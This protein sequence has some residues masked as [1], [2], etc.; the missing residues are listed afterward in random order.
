MLSNLR[1][2]MRF[3]NSWKSRARLRLFS[4]RRLRHRQASFPPRPQRKSRLRRSRPSHESR[5]RVSTVRMTLARPLCLSRSKQQA[6]RSCFTRLLGPPRTQPR[7]CSLLLPRSALSRQ[8]LR[9]S[10]RAPF[11]TQIC[12]SS[13]GQIRAS[14]QSRL[15]AHCRSRSHKRDVTAGQL[16][17]TTLLRCQTLRQA[18]SQ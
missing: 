14:R 11:R 15:A 6:L 18:P 5:A 17:A 2:L 4:P 13:R 9:Q 3:R 10:R 7:P 16:A 1:V 8:L 12:T